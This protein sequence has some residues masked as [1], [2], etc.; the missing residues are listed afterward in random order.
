MFEAVHTNVAAEYLARNFNPGVP[1]NVTLEAL[2]VTLVAAP[3]HMKSM[4]CP[5]VKPRE[6]FMVTVTAPEVVSTVSKQ[7][8]SVIVGVFVDAVIDFIVC[9]LLQPPVEPEKEVL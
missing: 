7:P 9:E 6:L 2:N 4:R 3:T 5:V 8:R 1:F